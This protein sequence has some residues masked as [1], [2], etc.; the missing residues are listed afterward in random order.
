MAYATHPASSTSYVHALDEAIMCAPASSTSYIIYVQ[1][2]KAV[3]WCTQGTNKYLIIIIMSCC[4]IYSKI[5]KFNSCSTI[6]VLRKN[7]QTKLN[8][9]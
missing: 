4:F 9:S 8:I 6:K 1:A 5:R 3:A 2:V 7:L